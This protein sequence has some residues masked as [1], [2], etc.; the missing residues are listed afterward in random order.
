MFAEDDSEEANGGGL[1]YG[2]GSHITAGGLG[3]A[4]HQVKPQFCDGHGFF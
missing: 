2:G 4:R 3:A 1:G